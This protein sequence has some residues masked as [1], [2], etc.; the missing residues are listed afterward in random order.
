MRPSE[1][2]KDRHLK[3]G[4]RL[5][6]IEHEL[7]DDEIHVPHFQVCRLGGSLAGKPKEL[8]EICGTLRVGVGL[9]PALLDR[10]RRVLSHQPVVKRQPEH[11]PDK[12]ERLIERGLARAVAVQAQP[13]LDLGAAHTLD[14]FAP[15]RPATWP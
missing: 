15:D 12:P 3:A 10:G 1:L 4:V 7:A 14:G 9:L 5:A 11:L 2:Q 8:D 13:R 6:P